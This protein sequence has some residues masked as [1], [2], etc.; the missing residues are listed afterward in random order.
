M[1]DV[2]ARAGAMAVAMESSFRL[3]HG[4]ADRVEIV[5][6]GDHGK[7]QNKGAT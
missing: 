7:E 2:L 4:L 1:G 5:A 6:D 3:F